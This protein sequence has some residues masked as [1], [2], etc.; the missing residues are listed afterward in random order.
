M[1]QLVDEE[2]AAHILAL[3]PDTLREWR[4]L[5]KGPPHVRI[6]SRCVRY[7]LRDLEDWIESRLRAST[8]DSNGTGIARLK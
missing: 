5:G 4:R 7:R 8:S 6:S 3:R 1:V 2:Q